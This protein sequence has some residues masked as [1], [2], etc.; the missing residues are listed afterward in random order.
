VQRRT[1][2]SVAMLAIGASLLVAA[3]LAGPASSSP[4][5]SGIKKGGTLRVNLPVTDIDDIDPSIAYGTTTWHIQYSTALKLLNYPDAA[6][7]RGGRLI[8]E[9]ATSYRVSG[10]GRV[11]TF[12]I[13]PGFRFSNG[14]RVTAANYAYA[15]NRAAFKDLQSPAFQF[16]SDPN[17]TNVVGAQDVRD[18]KAATMRGVRVRGNKLIVTLTKPDAT[19]LAKITMPFFQAM[20]T[21]LSKTDKVIN[22]SGNNL[23]SAGPYYV[24]AREPNRLVTLRKNPFY[25]R[26]VARSYKRRPAN[27]S[28]INIRTAVNLEAS[29]QEVRANQA[30]YTYDIPPTAP[31]E[32]GRQFGTTRGR[33][34]VAT[35]NCVSY[36]A[37]NSNNALFSGNPGL[38]RAV[39][40]VI[41]R[42]AMV[43]LSGAYA[44]R[45]TDQYLP[46]GFPGYKELGAKGYPA[47]QNLS[48]ARQ[49]AQGN[50]RSGRGVYY[51]GLAAPG[52]QRMELVRSYLSQIGI[53]IEPQGFRGFAIYDAAGKRNSPHA[54]TTGGWCQDYPDPYDF[55]N[56][57]L[58]GGNIQEENNNNLAYFNNATFNKRMERSAKLIGAP[59]MKAYMALENDLVTQQAPWAAWTQPTNQFFFSNR[60]DTRSLVYQNIY[61][62]YPYNVIALR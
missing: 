19:F 24:A 37:M 59:R 49:L 14:Q 38:R 26:G 47:T 48:R 55:I 46:R 10:G 43:D 17:G 28:A 42:N 12:T 7:P 60:V 4:S 45:Q 3:S 57:L 44:G 53:S 21:N 54:F 34:R 30:D 6:A 61:E 36:I 35:S 32:L 23:A 56:V 39:N 1:W 2:F 40:Y 22:V 51:Y 31:A 41:N 11:Y 29:Y 52:P 25:A 33:F 18:G 62:E 50:T 13:R 5:K 15:I 27:L 9:G 20:P 8:P 16:I 58:Y